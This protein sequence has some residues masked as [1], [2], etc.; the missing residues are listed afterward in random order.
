[1]ML[2]SYKHGKQVKTNNDTA[3]GSD[4]R[5]GDGWKHLNYCRGILLLQSC[6]VLHYEMEGLKKRKR[7]FRDEK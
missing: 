6:I 3:T 1:M 4:S 7:G 5:E 2:P